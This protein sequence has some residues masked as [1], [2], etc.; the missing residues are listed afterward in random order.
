MVIRGVGL[1]GNAALVPIF[2]Q[3]VAPLRDLGM[4]LVTTRPR[5]PGDCHPFSDIGIPT[6]GVIQ[7][8]LEYDTRTHHTNSDTYDRLVPED[9]RQAAVVIATLLYNT[10]MRDQMLP[11]MPVQ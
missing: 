2:Q 5:C 6:P 4:T 1:S 7:D 9:L 8:P 10:A 11:R 3:W